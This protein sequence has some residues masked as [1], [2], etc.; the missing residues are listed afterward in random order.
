MSGR[1]PAPVVETPAQAVTALAAAML[2][3]GLWYGGAAAVLAAVAATALAGWRGLVGAALGVLLGFLSSLAT[4]GLMRLAAA[5][6][7][8]TLLGVVLGGYTIKIALLLV[9]AVALRGAAWLDPTAFGL[10]VLAVVAA[11]AAAEV[12]AFRRTRIPTIIPVKND[13]HSGEKPPK[14]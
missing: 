7:V 9:A 14:S 2:R 4:M 12:V 5:L 3:T 6:P 8:E 10:S 1:R 13:G 11:W